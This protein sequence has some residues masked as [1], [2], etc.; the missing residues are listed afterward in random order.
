MW[1]KNNLKT[2]E[3]LIR[4]VIREEAVTK[5]EAKSFATK[6]DLIG[7]AR[8]TEIVDL[9]I[10]FIDNLAK[11]KDE[12]YKKIDSVLGRVKTAEEENTILVARKDAHHE[13]REKFDSRLK[14]LETIH[15]GNRHVQI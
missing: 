8:S 14:Q 9:K 1:T 2:L 11:W 3:Q 15:P 13:E 10:T 12:L 6:N 5:D 4:T 7:L